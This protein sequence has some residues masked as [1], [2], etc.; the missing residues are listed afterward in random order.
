MSGGTLAFSTVTAGRYRVYVS[1]GA[2][3]RVGNQQLS[4]H[5]TR[6]LDYLKSSDIFCP[7]KLFWAKIPLTK[8]LSGKITRI[9]VSKIRPA[10]GVR[11]CVRLHIDIV[12]DNA[13]IIF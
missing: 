10:T 6:L 4:I 9:F 1:G 5:I 12:L 13:N 8:N 7:R 3:S 2:P 11:S